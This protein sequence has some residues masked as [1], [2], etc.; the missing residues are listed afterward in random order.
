MVTVDDRQIPVYGSLLQPLRKRT[1]DILQVVLAVLAVAAVLI[2]G[3]LLTDF[4][5]EQGLQSGLAEL[6]DFVP[7]SLANTIYLVYGLAIFALPFAIFVELV[8]TRQWK[9]LAGYAAAAVLALV[10]LSI[11]QA[12]FVPPNWYYSDEVRLDTFLSQFL[13]DARWIAILTAILTVAGPW[14]PVR[15]RRIWWSLLLAF[16]P[17]HLVVSSVI[18]A[19]SMFGL[20][21]GL[22]I[23]SVIV[24][25]VGTPAL[26][27]PLASA[28][29]VLGQHG[30]RVE[31]LRVLT[32]A[33]SGPLRLSARIGGTIPPPAGEVIGGRI[34]ALVTSPMPHTPSSGL[35]DA[36][37]SITSLDTF[38]VGRSPESVGTSAAAGRSTSLPTTGRA[39]H[40][41]AARM[42]TADPLVDEPPLQRAGNNDT[43]TRPA[44]VVIELYGMHQSSRGG[45]SQLWKLLTMRSSEN[46]AIFASLHRM[47]EHRALMAMAADRVSVAASTPLVY[48]EIDRGWQLFAHSV[49]R[50]TPLPLTGIDETSPD[51]LWQSLAV[52]HDH[53]IFHGDL[54]GSE[55]RVEN[56]TGLFVG[57][58]YAELG[59]TEAR[60]DS[61]TAQLL[62]T[63]AGHF[64]PENAV[65]S[66][67]EA[68]GTDRVIRACGR[69]TRTA[70]P[71]RIRS[72]IP[73]SVRLMEEIRHEAAEQT[74]TDE[75][76]MARVTRIGRNQIVQLVLLVG[77]V[78]VGYPYATQA[79]LFVDELKSANW[80]WAAIGLACALLRYIGAAAA[81]RAC[82]GAPVSWRDLLT[83]QV[84]NTFTATTT[85]AGVGGLALSI[86]FLQKTGLGAV[87]ATAAI[88]LQ[89]T[90]QL[91]THLSLVVVF[92]LLAGRNAELSRF[93]PSTAVLW[94][95]VVV[96]VCVVCLAF[97]I[98]AARRWLI[99]EAGPQLAGVGNELISLARDPARFAQIVIGCG[100]TTVGAGMALWAAVQAFGGSISF[101]AV[102]IVTMVGGT[103][104]SAAPTPG[105]VGAVEAAL[106]GGLTAFGATAAIAVPAVLLYR[107]LTTWL[108]VLVGWP[109][110]RSLQ[111]RDLV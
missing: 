26:E 83:M 110:L 64:G 21:I 58:G 52:L 37:R 16:F 25:L 17:I 20:A 38:D 45:L 36:D 3:D 93:V 59:T 96:L 66:A 76:R 103:L 100:I 94:M 98:P 92:S 55:V 75:I 104:A 22:L 88:T 54:R 2:V 107:V 102:T 99:N 90:V 40:T 109:L 47:I 105:G 72:S 23:G 1:R 11:T 44:D 42:S 27:V 82:A 62:L 78:F 57:F 60:V 14:L 71:R 111:R 49:D 68:I 24:L 108:P 8:I 32:P 19:R 10:T 84:A 85:P 41:E 15:W 13:D 89:Q 86:R 51:A 53:Q 74:G 56:G 67:L 80:G 77:L 33:G 43:E 34:N 81:L 9:L 73:G 6:F 7:S 35:A 48:A 46:V 95:A 87:R 106:M 69:L 28:A 39:P 61:D 5:W 12:G 29:R 31:D 79:P 18:P 101:V 50:G 70:Q 65:R 91:V 97:A 63:T 4:G 30:Y